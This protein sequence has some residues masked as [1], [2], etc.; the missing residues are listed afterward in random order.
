MT[1][2]QRLA[3]AALLA[4]LLLAA[5]LLSLPT[6]ASPSFDDAIPSATSSDSTEVAVTDSPVSTVAST[7]DPSPSLPPPAP[8]E[9][10]AE[11]PTATPEP[12]ESPTL[13]ETS[14]ATATETPSATDTPSASPD[15]ESVPTVTASPSETAPTSPDSGS[16]PTVAASPSETPSASPESPTPTPTTTPSVEATSDSSGSSFAPGSVLINEVAW[17]GTLASTSDEWIDLWNPGADPI[18]LAGW[19]LTDS[20]DISVALAGEIG[21]HSLYLLERTNDQTV[22]DIAADRIYTGSLNNSGETL[23]LSDPAGNLIDTANASGGAWPA[24]DAAARASMERHGL[25]DLAANWATFPGVGGNG[26]DANGNPIAG[27]PRQPNAPTSATPTATASGPIGTPFPA[28]AV[29]INEVAWAGTLASTSDE[30]IELFNP[31]DQP[32]DLTDW[33][34][35]DDGDIDIGLKGTLDSGD[36]YLLERSDDGTIADIAADRIY[37]G[38]L[39]NGGERLRL[40]DPSGSEIDIVNPGAGAWPAG[41]AERR[42]SMERANGK[43][44]TFTGYFGLGHDADGHAVRGT[45]GGPNSILFPTP[46]PTWIPG[47]IVINEVLVRPHYDWEG[48]GGV[49]TADEFIELYNRGPGPVNLAG[50]ILDD[51]VVGGSAPYELPAKTLEPGEFAAF[52]R[53]RTHIALNDSGDSIRLSSPNGTSVDKL[54]YLRG[55]AYNLS[56]GRLP[57]GDDVLVY[58]L[59]P[60]PGKENRLFV[61]PSYPAGSVLINEVAWAGTLASANDEWIELWNPG[62]RSIHLDGWILTDDNDIR[63]DLVGGLPPGGYAIL[64]RTDEDTISNLPSTGIYHGALLDDGERLR[65]IDP[66]GKEIDVVD[67][68]GG[69]WPAGGGARRASMERLS[70]GWLTFIGG[71]GRGFDAQG[72]ALHGTPG[73]PNSA[74]FPTSVFR[75]PGPRGHLTALARREDTYP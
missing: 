40:I 10:D 53:S 60:T 43:W 15:S 58:G 4:G 47:R 21:A 57:D 28:E 63:I 31:G 12:S 48:A 14:S 22:S 38:G 45:P 51:I 32:I 5:P 35:T 65:L 6:S 19:S 18:P 39:A 73:G 16:V 69:G 46:T 75:V 72:N 71:I 61:P 41:D 44:R 56:Y 24:G 54:R 23:E 2:H 49:T 30:W 11:G 25:L 59:W 33:T 17:A 55:Q 8:T 3:R 29:I 20:G 13:P 9:T 70:D 1:Q 64:E 52:F 62:S 27:T 7:I 34:L 67:P 37:T 66:S 42:S 36:Y 26:A 68:G 74:L 50:W